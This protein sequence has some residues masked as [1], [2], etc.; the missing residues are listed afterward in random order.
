M[1]ES[2]RNNN[3][4]PAPSPPILSLLLPLSIPRNML[5]GTAPT[6]Q[7]ADT[8]QHTLL[9]TLQHTLQH[10]ALCIS[11]PQNALPPTAWNIL[12]LRGE[13][14]SELLVRIRSHGSLRLYICVQIYMC[15]YLSIY[16]YIYV[17]SYVYYVCM[18]EY[19][20]FICVLNYIYV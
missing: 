1:K 9:H 2:H 5:P 11:I 14:M 20:L 19:I 6:V 16:T 13:W 8:L 7:G 4:M 17:Y 15:K 12:P 18:C 10:T 3:H